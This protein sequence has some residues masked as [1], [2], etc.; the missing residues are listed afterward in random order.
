MDWQEF[1]Y[2]LEGAGDLTRLEFRAVGADDG[3]GGYLDNVSVVAGDPPPLFTEGDDTV[4]LADDDPDYG[5]GDAYD[6]LAGDDTVIGGDLDDVID[7][8]TGNDT[9]SGGDGDD[10]L[11]GGAEGEVMVEHERVVEHDLGGLAETPAPGTDPAHFQ[12]END[13][14]VSMTFVS[15]E[16]GYRNTVGVYKIGPNGEITDVEIV[17]ADASDSRHG[18]TEPGTAQTLDLSDGDS[19]GVFIV[20]DGAKR[21]PF[22]RLDG[23]HYEFRNADGSPATVDSIAPELVYVNRWGRAYELRGDVYHAAAGGAGALALN[24]DGAQHVTSATGADGALRLAFEDLSTD[25][26]HYDGDFDDVVLD[27]SFAPVVETYLAPADDNDVLSGGDGHDVLIGGYG[28]DVLNGD[29]GRDTL[30]GGV[31]DDVLNGGAGKDDLDGG[32]GDDELFGNGGDD[33]LRGGAGKDTLTGGNGDDKLIGGGG[34]DL[35]KG[36]NGDD[37][38]KGGGGKDTLKGGAGD[39]KLVGGKGDDKVLGGDGDDE[40]VFGFGDGVA[41]TADGGLGTDTLS[42]TVETDDLADPAVVTALQQLSAFI[43]N[44]ADA[45]ADDG[46]SQA[47]AALGIEVSN[48]EDIKVT[49]IDSETGEEVEGSFLDP[50]ISLTVADSAG[51]EDSAIGLAISAAVTNLPD[52]FDVSITISGLPAGAL[53]SAGTVNPDG[54]VTVDAGELLGLSLM[55]PADD[56]DDFTLSVTATA[57]NRVTGIATDGTPADIAVGVNAVADVPSVDLADIVLAD[58]YAGDDVIEGTEGKDTLQGFGGNDTITGGDGGDTLIGD[59]A[60]AASVTMAL[61]LTAALADTDGSETL[62]IVIAGLPPGVTLSAGTVNPDGSVS[63]A[64]GDLADLTITAPT[65]AGDF[66]LTVTALATD[67]DPDDASQS[68]ATAQPVS[69]VTVVVD[70]AGD[71]VLIGGAGKDTIFGNGGDDQ[72]FGDGGADTLMGEA[73]N[74]TISGGGGSDSID[75]GSGDDTVYG[76]NGQDVIFGGADNDYLY[77]DEKADELLGGD[78]DDRLWGGLGADTLFGDAGNDLLYGGDGADTLH[79][80]L[81]NDTVRGEVGNDVLFGDAGNDILVGAEGKDTLHGG[82]GDDAL[83][84]QDGADTLYGEDGDDILYG[85][86]GG[87]TLMGGAGN[88]TLEGEGGA[89]VLIGGEGVDV[90]FGKGGGDRFVFD[91]GAA[92]AES[93]IGAGN[94]DIIRNFEA[95][96]TS[97]SADTIEFTGTSAFTFVGDETQQFTGGSA[98]GRFNANTKILEIDADGDM[99]TDFEIELQNVDAAYLDDTDFTVS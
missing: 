77:G 14:A 99:N 19:F 63:L 92:T 48:F 78:G 24:A 27:I 88:D 57:T 95:D 98:S 58:T 16:A 10:V 59:G 32:D 64:A 33:E 86:G 42:I 68:T 22:H 2:E 54:S 76:G 75:G 56:A 43:V 55:P 30:S 38:L 71:D 61:P 91:L 1:T 72:L 53:L 20:A 17:F 18:G 21:N 26:R 45:G 93:G 83:F 62:S 5:D 13:H 35:L 49:V 79:G 11:I 70:V 37:V 23:G 31:G 60:G 82:T 39:D 84:G 34:K 52:I 94:R 29:A 81:G 15:E 3:R 73:G 51:D 97:G 36:G 6:A 7:G 90:M 66:A 85:G 9:L 67:T 96:N 69:A 12:L 65:T 46:P 44:N 4:V 87:D 8:N 40:V 89:D 47:F 80:G 41:E 50:E 74:D 28:D 25:N